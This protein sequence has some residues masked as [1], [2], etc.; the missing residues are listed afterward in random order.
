MI[1]KIIAIKAIT[2]SMWINDP[3]LYT[4]TPRAHEI[5]NISAI[6]YNKFD[7]ISTV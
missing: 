4:K 1:L 3:A 5:I 6:K 2:K 7:M